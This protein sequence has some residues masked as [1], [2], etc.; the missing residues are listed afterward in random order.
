MHAWRQSNNAS[1]ASKPRS[2]CGYASVTTDFSRRMLAGI[3][4]NHAVDELSS[5]TMA[6]CSQDLRY[7][8]KG[9]KPVS[10][11]SDG[12][13]PYAFAS[14]V[15]CASRTRPNTAA[16]PRLLRHDRQAPWPKDPLQF[17]PDC[18]SPG[19]LSCSRASLCPLTI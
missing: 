13:K 1:Q 15:F 19:H 9:S 2:D 6:C 5:E 8:I 11:Y 10:R 14:L 3:S 17:G 7:Q 18:E 16:S 12:G 4:S